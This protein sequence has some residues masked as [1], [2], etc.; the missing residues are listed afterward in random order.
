[1]RKVRESCE[2]SLESG[3]KREGTKSGI[4]KFKDKSV[5]IQLKELYEFEKKQEDRV[6]KEIEKKDK[7]ISNF[8]E[9]AKKILEKRKLKLENSLDNALDNAKKDAVK[10][11][12]GLVKESE[13]KIKSLKK[14]YYEKK[15]ILFNSL[16]D[17]LFKD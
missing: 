11:R 4:S 17:Y 1:M 13:K 6:A 15:D 2:D 9:R 8:K 7:E 14:K 16:L 10:E 3:S 5:E 12:E